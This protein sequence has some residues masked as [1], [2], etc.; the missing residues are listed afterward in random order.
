[1]ITPSTTVPDQ[2]RQESEGFVVDGFPIR[3]HD[4]GGIEPALW[5]LSEAMQVSS[6][7]FFAHVGLELGEEAMLAY[8]RRF[9]FCGPLE[10]GP[11]DRSLSVAPSYLTGA[12]DGDCGPFSGDVEL[13]SAAFGQGQ[14]VATPVQMALVAAAIAGDGVMPHP[15]VVR[16]VRTH[17]EDGIVDEH[18]LEA[19]A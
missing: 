13:A 5:P 7:I 12:V 18:P 3:E 4:L 6:N 2:P 9:G 16:D 11:P 8:A 10:I 15:Y 1:M 19:R 14:S 17:S